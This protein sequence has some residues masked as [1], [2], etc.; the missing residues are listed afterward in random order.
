[1]P[2]EIF[3]R[4]DYLSLCSYALTFPIKVR[5]LGPLSTA[6]SV[7]PRTWLRLVNWSIARV[8]PYGKSGFDHQCTAKW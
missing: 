4:A 3:R 8:W 1:M 7:I 6:G 2:E 5:T